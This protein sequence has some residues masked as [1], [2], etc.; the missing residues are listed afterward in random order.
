M[1]FHRVYLCEICLLVLGLFNNRSAIHPFHCLTVLQI[2][3]SSE[4]QS[5][6]NVNAEEMVSECLEF[7]KYITYTAEQP[8]PTESSENAFTKLMAASKRLRL[9]TKKKGTDRRSQ[10]YNT[11]VDDLHRADLG[12]QIDQINTGEQ[13]VELLTK[14]L[15]TVSR[16]NSSPI[17]IIQ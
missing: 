14:I 10:L 6:I 5:T 17:V 9:P 12:W 4:A 15:W 7:G 1:E 11:I 8:K 3:A 2:G 13:F 16:C